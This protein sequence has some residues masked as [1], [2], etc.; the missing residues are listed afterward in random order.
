MI[1]ARVRAAAAIRI[2]LVA[3]ALGAETAR[4]TCGAEG[5]PI[6]RSGADTGRFDFD[7]R[8]QEVTQDRLW[9]GSDATTLEA[10]IA[11]TQAHGEVEL[12]TR[13]RAWVAEGRARL[14]ERWAVS[15]SLPYLQREHRHWLRHTPRFDARFVDTFEYEGLGDAT[16]LGQFAAL[17]RTGGPHVTLQGGVKLPTGRQHVPEEERDNFGFES[18]LEPAARPGSGSTDW[19]AG[20]T[21][22]QPLPWR[23]A[24][25]V[26]ASVLMRWNGLGTE[27]YRM[28]EELQAALAAGFAPTRRVTLLAQLNWATHGADIAREHEEGAEPSHGESL[29]SGMR[30][31]FLTPGVSIEVA[32][33]LSVFALYQARL[34]T[35]TE[36]AAIVAGDHLLL[37]TS[38]ALGR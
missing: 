22:A 25:P 14:N 24:L 10:L 1:C 19:L 38:F 8:Y 5:C 21:F 29:H 33:G 16:V 4:A 28:G 32:Q 34:W 17:R 13:T 2:A 6:V 9:N 3:I 20:I 35:H 12:Y 15:A 7:L 37:G 23:G 27:D 31:L 11:D 26:T 18:H 30:A 36:S